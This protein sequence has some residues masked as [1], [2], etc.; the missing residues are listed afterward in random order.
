MYTHVIK[1]FLIT[2]GVIIVF[3]MNAYDP[4][5]FTPAT[6]LLCGL[7]PDWS[8]L[9]YLKMYLMKYTRSIAVLNA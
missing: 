4:A 8:T 5:S 6:A 1:S 3:R 7:H 2:S 9:S